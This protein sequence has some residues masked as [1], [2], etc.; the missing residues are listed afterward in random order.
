[1]PVLAQHVFQPHQGV[2]FKCGFARRQGALDRNFRQRGRIHGA[3]A[4][5]VADGAEFKN[6]LAILHLFCHIFP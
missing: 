6:D 5:D 1:M 4:H 2:L 3:Y